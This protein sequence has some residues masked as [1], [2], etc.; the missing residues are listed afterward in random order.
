MANYVDAKLLGRLF[1]K[2]LSP[3]TWQ[4]DLRPPPI[5][6]HI[7]TRGAPIM[8]WLNNRQIRL[9]LFLQISNYRVATRYTGN[10]YFQISFLHVQA[11]VLELKTLLFY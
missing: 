11:I 4:V 9:R 8:H 3:L 6:T 1:I 2:T 10:T 7:S 5:S